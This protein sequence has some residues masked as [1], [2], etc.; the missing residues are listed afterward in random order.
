MK[1]RFSLIRNCLHSG[2]TVNRMIIE[3]ISCNRGHIRELFEDG[4]IGTAEQN[5]PENITF[6]N[7]YKF[8]IKLKLFP[9]Q[10]KMLY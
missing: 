2:A 9:E 8:S 1:N 7:P 3:V 6:Q 5:L 4:K 10:K